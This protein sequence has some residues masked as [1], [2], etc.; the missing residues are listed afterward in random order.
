[1]V[2]AGALASATG[3]AA[4]GGAGLPTLAVQ[5]GQ[6]LVP[7]P[8]PTQIIPLPIIR[9]ADL[10]LEQ[11]DVTPLAGGFWKLQATLRNGTTNPKGF[12]MSYPGGGWLVLSRNSG[13]TMVVEPPAMFPAV[14]DGGQELAKKAIPA[15]ASGQAISLSAVTKGRA[16]FIA[17]AL[18]NLPVID[19]PKTSLPE[20]NKDNNSKSVD[21]LIPLNLTVN[22]A[23]LQTFLGPLVD[24]CQ[25]RFDKNDSFVKVPGVVEKHWTIGEAVMDLPWPLGE[26]RWYVHDINLIDRQVG[27]EGGGL[28]L[29]LTFETN[30]PEIVGWVDGGPDWLAPDVNANPLKVSVRLPLSYNAW[31]QFFYY[32]DPQ[33]AVNAHWS[34]NGPLPDSLLPDIN[35]KIESA[36]RDLLN[37]PKLK[38]QIEFELNKQIHALL[39]GGRIVAA[40]IQPTQI[41]LSVE[42]GG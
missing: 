40:N 32:H 26:A 35:G 37:N 4:S 34:L 36:V 21:K 18:P 10:V 6:I 8:A 25:V 23:L 12:R 20:V 24:Q 14:P 7:T 29:D 5:P 17:A 31:G 30:D 39:K 11:L 3:A 9:P 41:Q 38:A 33:V 22:S 27:I 19:G 28:S 15:L 42:V 2:M 13:G 1:V 16:I